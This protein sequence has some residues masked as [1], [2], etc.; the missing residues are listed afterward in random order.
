MISKGKI[1]LIKSLSYKKY[2]L[3]ENLFLVE[4]NKN[5]KE[6]LNA[7]Y[8]I[9]YLWIT[10]TFFAEIKN[11]LPRGIELTVVKQEDIKK[12]SLL[13]NP[14]QCLALCEIPKNNINNIIFNDQLTLYLDG[15]QDPGNLGTIIRT[16]DWFG[17]EQIYCSTDTADLY[18]PKVIQAT[19]GSFCR[20]QVRYSDL[21]TIAKAAQRSDIL[22]YGAYLQGQNIYQIHYPD[23]VL[24]VVGNE[25]QG[26]RSQNEKYIQQKIKIPG[27]KKQTS[28]E[29]INA[30]V[31]TGIICSEIKRQMN[32]SK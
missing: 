15:I 23:K 30:A 26:I 2:R 9:K 4:G 19:M 11:V 31:A 6:A 21:E 1:K 3:K 10:N 28:A 13:K 14:Q 5:V 18:N 20:C 27:F 24:L 16:C 8:K 7:E 12:A 25:G 32:Y 22:V 29:S 17:I